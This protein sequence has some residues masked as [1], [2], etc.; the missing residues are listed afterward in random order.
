MKSAEERQAVSFV[1]GLLLGA[2]IGAGVAILT[3]PQP[4][5]KTRRRIRKVA[6]RAKSQTT[7]RLDDLAMELKRRVDETVRAAQDRLPS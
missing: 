7:N 4:G 1:S 5:R 2:V 6:R 3:A